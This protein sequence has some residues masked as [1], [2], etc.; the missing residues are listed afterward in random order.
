MDK[1]R[2]YPATKRGRARKAE[3]TRLTA[4]QGDLGRYEKVAKILSDHFEGEW[5]LGKDAGERLAWAIFQFDNHLEIR[6]DWDRTKQTWLRDYP[7]YFSATGKRGRP[8]MPAFVIDFLSWCAAIAVDSR[9]KR[10]ELPVVLAKIH[11]AISGDEVTPEMIGSVGRTIR[12]Y[13]LT[14]RKALARG[15]AAEA[16][17]HRDHPETWPDPN[18]PTEDPAPAPTESEADFIG[19]YSKLYESLASRYPLPGVEGFKPPYIDKATAQRLKESIPG[20][21]IAGLDDR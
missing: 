14:S 2:R 1:N 13:K 6:S 11:A 20:V 16:R 18:V 19:S 5:A 7:F 3:L 9:Y 12:R 21:E 15:R 8:P 17:C 10:I 4:L